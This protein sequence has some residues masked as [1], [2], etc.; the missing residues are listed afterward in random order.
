M[1]RLYEIYSKRPEHQKVLKETKEQ[2]SWRTARRKLGPVAANAQVRQMLYDLENDHLPANLQRD[3]AKTF[4][5]ILDMAHRMGAQYNINTMSGLK[6]MM[7]MLGYND[8]DKLLGEV[9]FR[10]PSLQARLKLY[11]NRVMGKPLN[12]SPIS[13]WD[14][15]PDMD[16]NAEIMRSKFTGYENERDHWSDLDIAAIKN[17][18]F[19][20]KIKYGFGNVSQNINIFFW[21]S[22]DPDYD[23]FLQQGIVD[24]DWISK[25]MDDRIIDRI[26]KSDWKNSITIIMTNNLSDERFI[27][28]NGSWIVAHRIAHAMVGGDSNRKHGEVFSRVYYQFGS[29]TNAIMKYGYDYQWKSNPLVYQEEMEI[30]K[31]EVGH[32]LGTMK[33]ART[34]K[35]VQSSEWIYETFAQYLIQGKVRFNS[36]PDEL[37]GIERTKDPR[38]W[39]IAKRLS[40]K[41]PIRLENWYAQ[42]MDASVGKI[43]VI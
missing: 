6:D 36:L 2:P 19:Q 11:L 37:G 41:F 35:L 32:A 13:G 22:T 43:F 12:E 40:A 42:L 9:P 30:L 27:P 20:E 16:N 29:F 21:Q 34:G 14:I 28:I 33:S 5:G 17:D 15:D 24:F 1:S 10:D 39:E 4:M 7:T 38:K 8:V 18:E 31:R 25:K 23:D 26:K 3:R